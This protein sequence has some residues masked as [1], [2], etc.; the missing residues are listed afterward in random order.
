MDGTRVSS[1]IGDLFLT[2]VTKE[3]KHEKVFGDDTYHCG[4]PWLGARP[5]RRRQE[6]RYAGNSLKKVTAGVPSPS[7][8]KFQRG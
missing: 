5:D 2:E 1:R 4:L 7:Q 3:N 6:I 8:I